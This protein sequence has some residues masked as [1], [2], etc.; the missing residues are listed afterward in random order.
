[1]LTLIYI[2]KM[3]MPFKIHESLHPENPQILDIL[4]QTKYL[5]IPDFFFIFSINYKLILE[6]G[7]LTP[8]PPPSFPI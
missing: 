8:Q 6:V 4:I 1:M 3:W 2:N 5:K 7:D